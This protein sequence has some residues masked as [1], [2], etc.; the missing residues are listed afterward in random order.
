MPAE[1]QVSD[2]KYAMTGADA[3][4]VYKQSTGWLEGPSVAEY[5]SLFLISPVAF[6]IIDGQLIPIVITRRDIEMNRDNQAQWALE[7]EYFHAYD[8]IGLSEAAS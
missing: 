4:L 5:L 2:G 1:Y 8:L 7:F 6:E 3:T